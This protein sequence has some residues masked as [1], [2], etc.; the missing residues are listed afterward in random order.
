[1]VPSRRRRFSLGRYATVFQTEICSIL[2]C[3][4]DIQLLDRP[5]KHVSISF[6]SQAALKSLQA[7]RTTSLLVKQ[8][9]KSLND[10]S[11]RYAVGLYWV[12]GHPVIRGYEIADKLARGGSAQGFLGPEPAL[13][14]SRRDTQKR[15]NRWLINQQWARWQGLGGTQRQA[16]ELISGPGRDAKAKLMS[17]N[18]LAP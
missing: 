14:V 17:F 6:D 9:Q 5:E 18:P 2:A 7:T 4:Y 10:I 13:G 16:R 11:T 3:V 8:C 12:S 1:M 15:L